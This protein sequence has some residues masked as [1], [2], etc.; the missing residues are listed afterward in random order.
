LFLFAN[1]SFGPGGLMQ[2]QLEEDKDE[3][4]QEEGKGKGAA[5]ASG[6]ASR[7]RKDELGQFALVTWDILS[8]LR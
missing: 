2:E 1:C 3:K 4:E 8:G 5:Q 6:R 7:L